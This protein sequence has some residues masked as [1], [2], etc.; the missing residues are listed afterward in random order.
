MKKLFFAIAALTIL[1]GLLATG[2]YPW[3]YRS[4]TGSAE[5]KTYDFQDFTDV[6]I[7]SAIQYEIKYDSSYSVKVSTYKNIVDLLDI[8]QTG[9]TLFVRLK[10]GCYTRSDVRVTVSMPSVSK[11]E[12]SGA[13]RGSLK[14][15]TAKQDFELRISGASQADLDMSSGDSEMDISGAS[16]VRGNLKAGNLRLTVS[17]ASRCEIEG[18][19]QDADINVSGASHIA[20]KDF[21]L[22]NVSIIAGGASRAEIYTNGELS[23]DISG[24]SS[25]SY[26]GKPVLNKINVSGASKITAD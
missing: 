8:H 20:F 15:F 4:G 12:V 5:E 25:L 17:G 14:G 22:R 26:G 9:K 7:A 18:E 24:A 2:C 13:S 16:K 10:P 23:L 6:E 3:C 1:I 11:I 19:A 21:P